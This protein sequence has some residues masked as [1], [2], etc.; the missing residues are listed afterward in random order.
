MAG[1]V[2]DFWT[3]QVLGFGVE[4]YYPNTGESNK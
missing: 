1:G 2:H 3:A 4:G